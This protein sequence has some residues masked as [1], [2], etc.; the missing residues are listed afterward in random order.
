M[1]HSA[2]PVSEFT[3]LFSNF[4]LNLFFNSVIE[5]PILLP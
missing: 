5:N 4:H 1:T 2:F 3:E